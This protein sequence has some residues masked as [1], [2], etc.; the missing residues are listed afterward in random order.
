[1]MKKFFPTICPECNKPLSIETG[2]KDDVI[3]LVCTNKNCVG[4]ILKKLQ[5]GIIALEIRGL[6]PKVIEKL[7][8]AGIN[9]SYDLFDKEIFNEENL[10]ASGE[11]KKGRALEKIIN[12]VNSIKEIPIQK[13]ILSLQI[14]DIGKTFSEK[15]GMIVSGLDTDLT[16]L[17]ISVREALENKETGL[18]KD[19]L[20]SIEKFEKNGVT[21]KRIEKPKKVEQ[22]EVKKVTKC[23]AVDLYA[24]RNTPQPILDAVEK[25]GWEIVV[26]CDGRCSFLIVEDKNADTHE[27]RWAKEHGLKIMSLKQINLLFL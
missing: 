16:G 20:D 2:K 25:L 12:S 15:I 22:K 21:I 7:L 23:V 4:T 19:I 24:D 27:I 5:K 11:F 8:N 6:G 26:M 18:Y 3:K 9:H 10:I 17:L 14:D 1:M 13:A